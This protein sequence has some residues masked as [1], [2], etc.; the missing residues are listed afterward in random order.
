MT[1]QAQY[2]A[3][4]NGTP[5]N[6]Y[7]HVHF[8]APQFTNFRPAKQIK[9]TER[10]TK[11]VTS[12]HFSIIIPTLPG[13]SMQ[14]AAWLTGGGKTTDCFIH[15]I[16]VT[17][18]VNAADSGY[19]TVFND[20]H[21]V[22]DCIMRLTSSAASGVICYG[23]TYCTNVMRM[24]IHVMGFVAGSCAIRYC[25]GVYSCRATVRANY[26]LYDGENYRTSYSY[27]NNTF[28]FNNNI[29]GYW[30]TTPYLT[31]TS[32]SG[33]AV[34]SSPRG[35]NNLQDGCEMVVA[36]I[37][38]FT[39]SYLALAVAKVNT[40]TE[41]RI[42]LTGGLAMVSF[43]TT[44]SADMLTNGSVGQLLLTMPSSTNSGSFIG[45][46]GGLMYGVGGKMWGL[47]QV[48]QRTLNVVTIEGIPKD[49][50]IYFHFIYG[51]GQA[52]PD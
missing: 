12:N 44:I 47:T 15:G 41:V 31:C 20:V 22:Y 46:P 25:D 50:V 3:W 13:P 37:N 27:A 38:T 43:R 52:V 42:W 16:N 18:S 11:R 21:N 48:T 24:F 26:P 6:D 5:G 30:P 36:D 49:T 39:Q 8:A 51:F 7:T 19:H 1:N 32:Y 40:P 10:G 34:S 45:M 17:S 14:T 4:E 2:D 29:L 9:L 33:V 35:G 28:M 23:V